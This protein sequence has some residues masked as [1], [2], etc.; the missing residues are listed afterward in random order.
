MDVRDQ[1]VLVFGSGKSGIGACRLLEHR[2]ASVILYDGNAALCAEELK[3]KINELDN[4]LESK[5][6]ELKIENGQ[7]VSLSLIHI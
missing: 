7:Y 2:G 6:N 4:I 1:N 5:N 3:E